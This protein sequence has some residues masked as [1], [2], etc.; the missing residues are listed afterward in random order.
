MIKSKGRADRDLD[1]P[2]ALQGYQEINFSLWNS[3]NMTPTILKIEFKDSNR[4]SG[5]SR[6]QTFSV[7]GRDVHSW[8]PWNPP[9]IR[10]LL[11]ACCHN[12]LAPSDIHLTSLQER[13]LTTTQR[14]ETEK[15]WWLQ[16]WSHSSILNKEEDDNDNLWC[17]PMAWFYFYYKQ[18]CFIDVALTLYI[19]LCFNLDSTTQGLSWA[20]LCLPKIHILKA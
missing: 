20:K 11:S 18:F 1:W 12:S 15:K 5:R 14:E 6:N 8:K 17:W 19:K 9:T 13:D 2:K 3:P 10:Q 7:I 16:I 4:L